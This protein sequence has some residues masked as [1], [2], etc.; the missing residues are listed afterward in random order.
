MK[1]KVLVISDYREYILARPEAEIYLGLQREGLDITIMT[2]PGT[3]HGERFKKAGIKVIE[4]HPDKKFHRPSI[5]FIRN[6]LKEGG[7][8]I[9]HLYNSKASSNGLIAARNIPV[10]VVLYRGYAGHIHWYDPTLYLKYFHPR[11]DKIVCV[12]KAIEEE[13]KRNSVFVKHKG[14]TII[15]GHDLDWYGDVKPVASFEEYGIPRGAF[16]VICVAHVRP[17]KGIPYLIEATHF[18][19]EKEPIHFLFAGKGFD[20]PEI[21]NTIKRSPFREKIHCIGFQENPLPLVAAADLFVLASTRGEG[22]NKAVIEAMSLGVPPVIT[23]IP[24]NTD[25]VTDNQCGL[26]VP[27]KNPEALAQ[28]IL[29]LY[30]DT[31]L[32]KKLGANAREHIKNNLNIEGTVQKTKELYTGLVSEISRQKVN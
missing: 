15:K 3:I 10:K 21:V 7:Y 19:P 30:T 5:R 29:Q 6:V 17:M 23:I 12:T 27:P 11:V 1:I 26:L 22:I 31:G 18:L 28:A 14:V 2:Y 4:F 20:Q 24:G 16:V 13:I 32:R 25:I 8:H 9:L